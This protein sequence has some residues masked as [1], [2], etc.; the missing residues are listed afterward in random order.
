VA[1][2]IEGPQTRPK[3]QLVVMDECHL[4][5]QSAP[6]ESEFPQKRSRLPF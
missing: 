1:E 2:A 3:T 5:K 4:E 6:A